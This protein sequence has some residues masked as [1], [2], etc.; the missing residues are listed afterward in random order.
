LWTHNFFNEQTN[1][2]HKKHFPHIWDNWIM[3]KKLL[4][5]I[6]YTKKSKTLLN[7]FLFF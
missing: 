7:H 1:S 3:N 2:S 6:S 5:M 4:L